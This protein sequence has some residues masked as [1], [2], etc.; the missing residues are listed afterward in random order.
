MRLRRLGNLLKLEFM[1][2]GLNLFFVLFFLLVI[3]LGCIWGYIKLDNFYWYD[4]KVIG[5]FVVLFVYCIG[6]YL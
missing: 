6:L 5:F 4:M 3:L 2:Y 1:F